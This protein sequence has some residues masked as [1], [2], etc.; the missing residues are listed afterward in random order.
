[1]LT[2][3]RSMVGGGEGAAHKAA[4][5]TAARKQR[6]KTGRGGANYGPKGTPSD[7]LPAARSRL[8]LPTFR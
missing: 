4:Q 6:E 7:L 3:Q 2:S 8:F 1:M 5:T